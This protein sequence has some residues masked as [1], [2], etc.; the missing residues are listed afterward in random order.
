MR[1]LQ[2]MPPYQRA[3]AKGHL[4]SCGTRYEDLDK[5]IIAIVNSWNDIVPGHC[6]LRELAEEVK[7]GVIEAGGYPLEFNTIAICDGIAQ[8]H[9]GMKY[10]LPSRELIADSV[11]AMIL[12]HGIF[13][14][15][16][17]LASCD[18]IVPGMLMAAGRLDMPTVMVTGGPMQNK[19]LPKKSKEARQAFLRGEIG[20]KELVDVT[21]EYYPTPG[22]CPF[23]GT[24]NTMCIVAETLGLSLPGSAAP[25]ALSPERKEIARESGRAV[26]ELVQK[27]IGAR[28]ILTKEAFENTMAVVSSMGGSLNTFLH[29]PAIA[30]ECGLEVTFGDYDRISRQ[31]PLLTKLVPNSQEYTMAD[32]E[33]VGGIPAIMKELE[34]LLR[35]NAL[36]V[37]CKTLTENLAEAPHADGTV[38]RPRTNP[39]SPEGGVAVLQGNLAPEGAVV[40]SSAVAPEEWQFR[41]PAKVYESEEEC[42]EH[43]EQGKI[44]PGDVVIVRNEGPKGGPGMREMHRVT[45]VLAKVGHTALITDGRYSGA[46]GGLA[47]GYLSPE[48]AD[49][50]AIAYVQN[51]DIISID[52]AQRSLLWEVSP[53]EEAQRRQEKKPREI[54]EDSLL[55]KLYGAHASS[56]SRGAVRKA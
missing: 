44:V 3:I 2:T 5:P 51:G 18:K 15:M 1:Q 13:D 20:E 38:I 36:A 49:D 10:V 31:T 50:G 45:E 6:H 11:E 26:L 55:L 54:E 32:L 17:M 14:G 7:Q 42:M 21:L 35:G 33:P 37:N 39:F 47:I 24:A 52:I 12:G 25:L 29:L 30:A 56:A 8:G 48:A 41:G 9:K 27:G 19:V 40:K 16:V 53:E 23:L 46:S 34:P 28:K 43:F 22:V 4:C